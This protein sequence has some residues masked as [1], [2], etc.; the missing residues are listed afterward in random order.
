[1]SKIIGNFIIKRNVTE[2][3]IETVIVNGFEGGIGYWAGLDTSPDEWKDI[4]HNEPTSMWATKI[5]LNGGNVFIYDR[6]DVS[7][8]WVLN[9]K[10]L[11]RGIELN[12]HRRPS[13]NEL[14]Q[15]DA[16]T[17]DCIIQYALFG[18]IVYG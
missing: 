4:P 12:Y 14:S 13:D 18:E 6:E 1:M 10:K 2:E 16:T 7:E 9:L 3:D 17:F 8:R 5:I 11:I 15:G